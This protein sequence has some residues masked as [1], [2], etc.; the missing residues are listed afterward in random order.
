MGRYWSLV[1]LKQKKKLIDQLTAIVKTNDIDQINARYKSVRNAQ[2]DCLKDRYNKLDTLFLS[3]I[4]G[5]NFGEMMVLS[6]V[7][8]LVILTAI[9]FRPD[10]LFGDCFAI[11]LSS[12]VC[13]I[14]FTVLDLIIMRKRFFL[15]IDTKGDFG[16]TEERIMTSRL[17]QITSIILIIMVIVSM[18]GV[19]WSIRL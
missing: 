4:Q 11:V 14:Y 12:A 6:M 18:V 8:L 16:M 7:G 9:T 15:S 3:R 2:H 5:A 19:M 1:S 13:F 17:D 10:S